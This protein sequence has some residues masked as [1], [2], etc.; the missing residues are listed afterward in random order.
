MTSFVP[1]LADLPDGIAVDG[2]LVAFG[3]DG[4]PS[5]PKLCDRMLHGKRGVDVML[6]VFDLVAAERRDVTRRPYWE[7]RQLLVDLGLDGDAWATSP[8]YDDGEAL[9]TQVCEL[10]LEGVVA[11]KRS[12]HYLPGRRGW[13]KTKNRAYWRYAFEVEAARRAVSVAV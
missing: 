6:I 3:D 9:W 13:I 12:G 10:G 7:R 8:V 11:K 5:F 4:L 2:E 1:E